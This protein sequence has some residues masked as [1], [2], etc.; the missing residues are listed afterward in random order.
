M[1][2]FRCSSGQHSNV[3]TYEQ[4]KT[5]HHLDSSRARAELV[6]V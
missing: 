6:T 5:G 3:H 2:S 4:M 1:V